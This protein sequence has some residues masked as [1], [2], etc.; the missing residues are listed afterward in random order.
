MKT[1]VVT[2]LVWFGLVWVSG[3]VRAEYSR[4]DCGTA[5]VCGVPF[6]DLLHRIVR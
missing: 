4:P 6:H 2:L 3:I 1:V 5:H